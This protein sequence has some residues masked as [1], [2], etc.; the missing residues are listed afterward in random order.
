M[1]FDALACDMHNL[2]IVSN[3]LVEENKLIESTENLGFMHI[4]IA[5]NKTRH[6]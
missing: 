1:T 4:M 3:V 5:S 2:Y 6:E